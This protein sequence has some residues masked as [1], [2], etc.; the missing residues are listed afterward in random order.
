MPSFSDARK[1]R[2][3]D[4]LKQKGRL[5]R[6]GILTRLG[7]TWAVVPATDT[8]VISSPMSHS[9]NIMHLLFRNDPGKQGPSWDGIKHEN[10]E[11]S[12][13]A[14]GPL[15]HL[16]HLHRQEKSGGKKALLPPEVTPLT[17][18]SPRCIF[19]NF[20]GLLYSLKLQRSWPPEKTFHFKVN[21][22][23]MLFLS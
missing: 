23:K 21:A 1:H 9:R 11:K 7:H 20:K 6:E 19:S 12:H 22:G 10:E 15:Q 4:L 2:A 14:L 18:T 16:P 17:S 3:K 8:P 5:T 13:W